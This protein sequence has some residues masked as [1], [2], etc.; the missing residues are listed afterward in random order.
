MHNFQEHVTDVL[1]GLPTLEDL[2]VKL[3]DMADQVPWELKP[4]RKYAYY[5]EKLGEWP[6]PEPPRVLV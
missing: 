3:T 5:D 6:D 4:F 2:G 1:T